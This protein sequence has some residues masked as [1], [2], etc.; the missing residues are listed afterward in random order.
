[1]SIHTNIFKFCLLREPRNNDS[2]V[3][4]STL[5][6]QILVSKYRLF[7]KYFSEKWLVPGLG[8]AKCNMNAK[9]H[10]VSECKEMLTNNALQYVIASLKQPPVAN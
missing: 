8:Q 1:M 10:F 7:T 9:H 5:N 3:A 4:T 2:P 6:T